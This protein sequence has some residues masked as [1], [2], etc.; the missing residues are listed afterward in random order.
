[1][2]VITDVDRITTMNN[3]LATTAADS[4]FGYRKRFPP[5]RFTIPVLT[6]HVYRS[7][8]SFSPVG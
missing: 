2:D 7:C 1:M 4:A 8:Y 6:S 5:F 3:T